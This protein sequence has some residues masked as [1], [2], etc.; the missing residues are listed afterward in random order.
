MKG[1]Y[2]FGD[3]V[4][5][6]DSSSSYDYEDLVLRRA[7]M[8]QE[9]MKVVPMP[10]QRGFV[11]PFTSWV[12][13]AASMKEFYGQPRHYLTNVQMKKFDHMR[14]GADNEDVPLDTIIVS[15]L[16]C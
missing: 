1:A 12:G 8:Y 11:I 5:S 2:P 6:S 16:H 14:L 15:S 10:T 9:Y 7:R 13:F 3:Q 4:S